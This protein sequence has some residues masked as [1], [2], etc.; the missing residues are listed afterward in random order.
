[1]GRRH[2]ET[3]VQKRQMANRQMKIC[4]TLFILREVQTKTTLRYHL[5]PARVAKINNTGNNWCW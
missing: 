1:M 2:E 3:F 5:T 4:A